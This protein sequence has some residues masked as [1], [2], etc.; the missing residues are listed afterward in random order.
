VKKSIRIIPAVIAGFMAVLA[1][2]VLAGA[3]TTTKV[4][5]PSD[6]ARQAEDTPPTKNWVSYYRTPEST[7]N[8]RNGPETPPLNAGSL[9]LN[10]PTGGDK[11]TTFNFDHSGDKLSAIN[12]MSYS[13]YRSSGNLQ[14]VAS[15]NLQ[16]DYNGS[17]PGGFTTLIFE[18]VYNTD[19]GAVTSGEWQSWD[20]YN[21]GQA[22]WWSSNPIPGAPDRDTFPTWTTIIAQNP[23]AVILGGVGINQG[24]GNPALTTAVDKFTYGTTANTVTYD[25]ELTAPKPVRATDKDQCKNGNYKNFQTSYKNQGDCVSD[26]ASGGK[27]KGNPVKNDSPFD[28]LMKFFGL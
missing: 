21:G 25:F 14:Q 20:A 12:A 7:A 13:T 3:E 19:Q 24:S 5:L 23:D 16:V 17:A 27:A 22:H 11:I 28:S 26:V 8:F 15:L 2:P 1:F 4:V 6:V 9:E 18:P 10:T